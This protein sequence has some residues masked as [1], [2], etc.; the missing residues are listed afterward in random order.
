ME[1]E[2]IEKLFMDG[3]ESAIIG[4]GNQYTKATL[5]FAESTVCTDKTMNQISFTNLFD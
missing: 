3:H 1:Y 5:G 2:N 4:Y